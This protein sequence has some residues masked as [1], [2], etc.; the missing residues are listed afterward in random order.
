MN[1]NEKATKGVALAPALCHWV[2]E[3]VSL[4]PRREPPR[5]LLAHWETD[6]EGH[7]HEIWAEVRVPDHR[8]EQK[9]R[10]VCHWD[11]LLAANFD[12]DEDAGDTKL[13]A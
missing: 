3:A 11:G 8:I 10:L 7:L 6:E 1:A 2:T 5:R 13:T 9:T 4:T 12:H